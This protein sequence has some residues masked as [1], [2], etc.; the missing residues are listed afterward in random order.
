MI[1]K[2][3]HSYTL[4]GVIHSLN[5]SQRNRWEKRFSARDL[6]MIIAIRNTIS[7]V[8]KFYNNNN[9]LEDSIREN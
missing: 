1:I 5:S 8:V 3:A 6:I 7:T 4:H 9:K 2:H